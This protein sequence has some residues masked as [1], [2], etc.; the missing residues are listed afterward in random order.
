MNHSA[1][2]LPNKELTSVTFQ[3]DFVGIIPMAKVRNQLCK[4]CHQLV[5]PRAS[6]AKQYKN[7]LEPDFQASN[8]L[9]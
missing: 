1:E 3:T 2:N 8:T 5:F 7:S 4:N 9:S 6:Y